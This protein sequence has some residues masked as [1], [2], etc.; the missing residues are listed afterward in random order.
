MRCAIA[1]QV[2]V[3][4]AVQ[5]NP[6]ALH[7]QIGREFH[8]RVAVADHVAA[9]L[10]DAVRR[11]EFLHHAEL[12]FAAGAVLAFEMRADEHRF[13][14]DALRAEQIQNEALR[15]LERLPRKTRAS[16]ARPDS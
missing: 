16:P 3:R 4:L 14:L 7:A 11:E 6:Q 2:L 12:G 10:V 9:R 13:E 8:V 5:A 15:E 1:G